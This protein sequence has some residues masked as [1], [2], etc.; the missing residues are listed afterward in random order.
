LKSI[1]DF[2]ALIEDVIKMVNKL[3]NENNNQ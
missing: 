3:L 1:Q 2:R